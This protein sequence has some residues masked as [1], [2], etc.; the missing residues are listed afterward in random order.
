MRGFAAPSTNFS[1]NLEFDHLSC[2]G[3]VRILAIHLGKFTR[4]LRRI[5]GLGGIGR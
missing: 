1:P 4:I 5:Q 2:A 3:A